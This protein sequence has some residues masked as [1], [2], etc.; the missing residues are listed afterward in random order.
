MGTGQ[1]TRVGIR[2]KDKGG[3]VVGPVDP[4]DLIWRRIPDQLEQ[5][6]S[7][8]FWPLRSSRADEDEDAAAAEKALQP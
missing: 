8:V 4:G 5:G 3:A 2:A 6:D 7:T 1:L